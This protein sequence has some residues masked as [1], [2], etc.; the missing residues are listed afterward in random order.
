MVLRALTSQPSLPSPARPA[1]VPK[2]QTNLLVSATLAQSSPL[3]YSRPRLL[4]SAILA[5]PTVVPRPRLLVSA[6]L[7][8][9]GP[10]RATAAVAPVGR[11]AFRAAPG[12]GGRGPCARGC[13]PRW[14]SAWGTRGWGGLLPQ[15]PSVLPDRRLRAPPSPKTAPPER[16]GEHAQAQWAHGAGNTQRRRGLD[17]LH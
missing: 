8:W 5:Q 13:P 4:V 16:A 14:R 1:V 17:R 2:D 6:I 10:H 11:R 3:R 12:R 9:R 15:H 7:A